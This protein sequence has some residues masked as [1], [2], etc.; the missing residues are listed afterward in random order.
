MNSYKGIYVY[1]FFFMTS[2]RWQT[3]KGGPRR[4]SKITNKAPMSLIVFGIFDHQWWSKIPKGIKLIG[5]L[6]G[7]LCL[8]ASAYFFLFVTSRWWQTKK[9]GPRQSSKITNKAPMSLI[10]FVIFDHQWWSK[11][12]KTIKLIGALLDKLCLAASAYIENVTFSI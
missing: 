7:K 3:K 5:A 11:I 1:P 10:F 2:R 4:S 8:A 9:G 12:T 6:L